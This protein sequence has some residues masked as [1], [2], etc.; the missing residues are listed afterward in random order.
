MPTPQSPLSSSPASSSPSYKKYFHKA[1]TADPQRLHI[2]AHSHHLWPDVV[3]EAQVQCYRD[4]L[5]LADTKWDKFF[6]EILPETQNRIARQ[7]HL[8]RPENIA[9]DTNTHQLFMRLLSAFPAGKKLRLLSTDSE[10]HSFQRQSARLEEEKLLTLHREKLEPFSSF[11]KRFCERIE[12]QNWDLI[13]LSQ[14]FFNSGFA[15]EQEQIEK[16]VRSKQKHNPDSKIV[17]DGY[18]GFMALPTDLSSVEE[19]LHYLAGG[20]K[21]AMA[22]EG[23]CFL[24]L[25]PKDLKKDRPRN[26]GWFAGFDFLSEKEGSGKETFYGGGAQKYMGSTLEPLGIYRMHRVQK[27]LQKELCLSVEKIHEHVKGLQKLFLEHWDTHK[28]NIPLVP[29][30]PA[31]SPYGHFL[32]FTSATSATSAYSPWDSSSVPGFSARTL[33]KKLLEKNIITDY[34]HP[35]LRFGFGLYHEASDI[36]RLIKGLLSV[37][38]A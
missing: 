19:E 3:W 28:Q 30:L 5:T 15:L 34:R 38:S 26:T 13:F 31:Q 7:L 21:Y 37:S 18:H 24:Y 8:K 32:S 22:G 12:K 20:Y 33:Q 2:A 27:W 23:A 29:A 9:F 16:M 17:L 35:F 4:A 1:L 36:E 11:A 10:F 14:V 6:K 25:P